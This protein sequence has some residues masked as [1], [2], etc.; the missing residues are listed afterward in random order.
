MSGSNAE[1]KA[2]S[3]VGPVATTSALGL[4]TRLG[5][6]RYATAVTNTSAAL[7]T[8]TVADGSVR[9][10]E[11]LYLNVKNESQIDVLTFAFGLGSAPVL[12]H[13]TLATFATGHVAAGWLLGP[14]EEKS[15]LIPAGATHAAWILPG[16]GTP[17]TIAFY[18]SEG[19]V[20]V[21]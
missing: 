10:W 14:N 6:K 17:S 16:T 19:K 21:K 15:I 1:I 11:G 13:G 8:D 2:A 3:Y 7:P 12:V 20:P 18:V 9:T 4:T 5:V